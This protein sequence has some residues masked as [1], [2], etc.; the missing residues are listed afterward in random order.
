MYYNELEAQGERWYGSHVFCEAW[1]EYKLWV[2]AHKEY[3]WERAA[4][5]Y[6]A[7]DAKFV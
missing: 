3:G 4:L 5:E 2:M 6:N 1:A 7:G